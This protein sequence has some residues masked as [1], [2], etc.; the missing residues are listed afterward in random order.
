[1]IE[2]QNDDLWP[3]DARHRYRLYF[4]KGEEL[5]VMAATPS[6]GGI[7]VAIG[8]LYEDQKAVGETLSAF[9]RLGVMDTCPGGVPSEEGEWIVVPFRHGGHV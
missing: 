6:M 4:L 3:R 8:A 7:G 1:M 9:G 5:A 2:I